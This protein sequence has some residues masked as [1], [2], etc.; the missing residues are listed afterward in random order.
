VNGIPMPGDRTSN[1]APRRRE[2]SLDEYAAGVQ[3][4]DVGVLARAVTLIESSLPRHQ[5]MAEQLLTRLLPASGNAIR[6]G[7]TGAPGSGKSTFIEALG[8]HLVGLGRR[9]AVLAVDPTSGVTGGSIL[10]DKTR[11]DRLSVDPDAFIRPS[12]TAGTLGGVTR[13]TRETMV[14]VEAAGYDTVIVETVGVGQSEIT[15]AGMVD[16]F[17]VLALART[18][19]SLQGIKRGIL[20]LADVVAVN[21]AD[22]PH[23]LDAESTAV[24]L[25]DA[26]RLMTPHGQPV[27]PVIPVSGLESWNLDKLWAEITGHRQALA[28]RGE[29]AAKHQRQ[30]VEWMWSMVD[31]AVLGRVRHH[32]EVKRLT[33]ELEAAVTAGECTPTVAARRLLTAAA[34]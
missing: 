13:T 3:A 8:L 9:V 18:G 15:V 34:S 29:L 20:E 4:G 30:Q 24:E 33:A 21:K 10:G 26:L 12:P 1:P 25:A 5:R 17:C 16:T 14:I 11:M 27:A 23:R 28:D 19:D 2:L 31:E 32:P 7:V 22:G 6:V